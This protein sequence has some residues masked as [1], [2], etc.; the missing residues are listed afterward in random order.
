MDNLRIEKILEEVSREKKIDHN[1]FEFYRLNS[2]KKRTMYKDYIA[3]NKNPNILIDSSL[4]YINNNFELSFIHRYSEIFRYTNGEDIEKLQIQQ[5]SENLK[6]LF[7]AIEKS[8]IKDMLIKKHNTRCVDNDLDVLAITEEQFDA[9]FDVAANTRSKLAMLYLK[10]VFWTQRYLKMFRDIQL[11]AIFSENFKQSGNSNP[12]AENMNYLLYMSFKKYEIL[13][14]IYKEEISAKGSEMPEMDI[15]LAYKEAYKKTFDDIFPDAEN[16]MYMDYQRVYEYKSVLDNLNSRK[17]ILLEMLLKT[18]ISEEQTKTLNQTI[19]Q[20]GIR[21]NEESISFG[22]EPEGYMMT[23]VFNYF[24]NS[25]SDILTTPQMRSYPFKEF[26]PIYL[27]KEDNQI[28][29][30]AVLVKPTPE[31]VKEI[32]LQAKKKGDNQ[33]IYKRILC[34]INGKPYTYEKLETVRLESENIDRGN[35]IGQSRED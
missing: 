2:I 30:P 33:E 22:F 31:Q 19:K 8:G 24:S 20:W 29:T 27:S 4:E 25:Y 16:D 6:A 21:Q 35:K 17:D 28:L 32:K 14:T 10:S 13:K 15:C 1:A 12:S 7:D 9:E 23:A 18:Q 3:E 26:Q 11:Q 5:L 34:Q